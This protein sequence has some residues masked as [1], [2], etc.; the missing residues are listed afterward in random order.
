[1]DSVATGAEAS[2][3]PL[4]LNSLYWVASMTKLVTAVAAAQLIERKILDLDMDVRKYV[5]ELEGVRVLRRV[6]K[7]K[8]IS[9]PNKSL[10]LDRRITKGTDSLGQENSIFDPVEGQITLRYDTGCA[11]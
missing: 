4:Q 9:I 3:K 5:K 11:C 7:G 8:Y 1:M 10:A 2:P 6:G